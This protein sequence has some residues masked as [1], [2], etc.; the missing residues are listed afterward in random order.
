M[1]SESVSVYKAANTWKDFGTITGIGAEQEINIGDVIEYEGLTYKVISETAVEVIAEATKYGGA[2]VIPSEIIIDDQSY[3]VTSIGE[4]AFEYCTGLISITIPN[5]ITS[6]GS[7]AFERCYNL[8][9]VCKKL[10][11]KR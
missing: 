9:S 2:I 11:Q 5:S 6:M 10:D 1:P 4:R 8:T 3:S 7:G